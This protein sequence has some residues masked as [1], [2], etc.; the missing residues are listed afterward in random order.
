[1]RLHARAETLHLTVEVL[2]GFVQDHAV[3]YGG[4][5]DAAQ[6]QGH[7]LDQVVDGVALDVHRLVR[8]KVDALF[9]HLQDFEIG[10]TQARDG[11]QVVRPHSVACGAR[12]MQQKLQVTKNTKCNIFIQ[13][14]Y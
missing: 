9:G 10:P 12:E 6:A 4:M 1:M 2:S 11:H 7:L 5:P 14:N 8:V 13:I 3:V